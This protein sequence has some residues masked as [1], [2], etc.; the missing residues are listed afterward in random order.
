[1]KTDYKGWAI[2]CIAREIRKVDADLS[3]QCAYWLSRISLHEKM[4]DGAEAWFPARE[5]VKK[6]IHYSRHAHWKGKAAMIR[7]LK[8]QLDEY[9]LQQVGPAVPVP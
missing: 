8:R 6:F 1:M 5:C 2:C 3:Y 9:Q 4:S 7:E